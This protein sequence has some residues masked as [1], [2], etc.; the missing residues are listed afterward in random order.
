MLADHEQVSIFEAPLLDAFAPEINTV[1]AVQVLYHGVRTV[2]NYLGVVA[3]DELAID[4]KIVVAR[5]A[6]DNASLGYRY[7]PCRL[8]LVTTNFAMVSIP[9]SEPPPTLMAAN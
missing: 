2:G 1:G 9:V 6:K 3:T 8:F 5:A 4:L 7:F